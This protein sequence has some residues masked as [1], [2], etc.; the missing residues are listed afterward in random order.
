MSN[1]TSDTPRQYRWRWFNWGLAILAGGIWTLPHGLVVL[2][3]GLYTLIGLDSAANFM[4]AVMQEPFL[5]QLEEALIIFVACGAINL[6]LGPIW[7]NKVAL[8]IDT[9]GL[10][11]PMLFTRKLDWDEIA[12]I[13]ASAPWPWR[14]IKI[15]LTHDEPPRH[16]RKGWLARLDKWS[17]PPGPYSF[18]LS[19]WQIDFDRDEL[20]A[21][22]NK[23]KAGGNAPPEPTTHPDPEPNQC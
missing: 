2:Q 13:E 1:P 23:L 6:F 11:H 12:T 4:N 7:R 20:L 16:N 8:T 18:N 10:D 15:T 21:A 9:D 19:G 22:M 3:Q 5:R 14:Q 17:V